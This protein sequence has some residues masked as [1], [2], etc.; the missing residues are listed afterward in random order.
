MRDWNAFSH[1][2]FDYDPQSYTHSGCLGFLLVVDWRASATPVQDWALRD[3]DPFA[4]MP[5]CAAGFSLLGPS[6]G[7][8]A[9]ATV[10]YIACDQVASLLK[11][12]IARERQ[13]T[14]AGDT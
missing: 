2:S 10:E 6:Q 12:V 7:A 8:L 3:E 4:A 9:F 11:V 13:V 5:V 1:V 14:D